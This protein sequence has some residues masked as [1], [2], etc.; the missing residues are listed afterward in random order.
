MAGLA[1]KDIHFDQVYASD[2]ERAYNTASIIYENN[3]YAEKTDVSEF[4]QSVQTNELL[5]ERSFGVYELKAGDEFKLAAK[6]A[7]YEDDAEFKPEGGENNKEVKERVVDFLCFL[8]QTSFQNEQIEKDKI[9][10]NNNI[11]VVSHGGWIWQ[12]IKYFAQ[13]YKTDI[14]GSLSDIN[15]N[16]GM[17][18]I[19]N[20]TIFGFDLLIDVHTGEIISVNCTKYNSTQHLNQLEEY[21]QEENLTP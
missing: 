6:E 5:R 12:L 16:N 19:K 13:E 9:K 1:I 8:T 2:L 14:T 11:L 20:T 3:M 17:L 21:V 18:Y 15:L 4:R 10:D 7:G